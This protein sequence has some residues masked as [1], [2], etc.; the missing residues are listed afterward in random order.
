MSEA[1]KTIEVLGPG[2]ARCKEAFRV[3]QQ[4]VET[5]GLSCQVVKSESI[6][7]MVELGM[8]ASPGVAF[9]GKLVLFGRVPKPEEIR[10]L[11]GI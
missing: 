6:D 9:D 3:V 8:M 2:C 1:I 10:K 5:A 4:V 11:L 7:R